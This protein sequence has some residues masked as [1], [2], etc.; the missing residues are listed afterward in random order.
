MANI[1]GFGNVAKGCCRLSKL[2]ICN[3]WKDI[4]IHSFWTMINDS[5]L[6]S[7]QI[8]QRNPNLTRVTAMAGRGCGLASLPSRP[9]MHSAKYLCR[10]SVSELRA[11][12]S[13][14][15][16]EKTAYRTT[17]Q[18]ISSLNRCCMNIQS[19]LLSPIGYF[20]KI[21]I[22]CFD[23]ADRTTWKPLLQTPWY[24]VY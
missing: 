10:K 5:V 6:L 24:T 13:K 16:E 17:A 12:P 15:E 7:N 20:P 2:K 21:L 9:S 1:F 18:I 14:A 3:E 22:T 23:T 4:G 11:S 19:W 8:K